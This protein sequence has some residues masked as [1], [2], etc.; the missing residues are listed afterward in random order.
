MILRLS[1]E[2]SSTWYT[3]D[4]FGNYNYMF[5][6]SGGAGDNGGLNK[7]IGLVRSSVGYC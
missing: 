1:L 5:E 7:L 4:D 3:D 2:I 6:V